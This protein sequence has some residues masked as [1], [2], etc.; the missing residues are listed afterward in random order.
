MSETPK[1]TLAEKTA[2]A[3]ASC[4]DIHWPT[5]IMDSLRAANLRA[6]QIGFANL[7]AAIEAE[8]RRRST[9]VAEIEREKV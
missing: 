7:G 2:N 1:L 8:R 6:D 4:R 3:L 5:A 9:V